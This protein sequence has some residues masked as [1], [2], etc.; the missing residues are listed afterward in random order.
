MGL[1]LFARLFSS[2]RV[3]HCWCQASFFSSLIAIW[4]F[5]DVYDAYDIGIVLS[6][7]SYEP[8]MHYGR[9]WDHL[10]IK[11]ESIPGQPGGYINNSII[12]KST[13]VFKKR[14][15]IDRWDFG[16]E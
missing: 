10:E 11:L 9:S 16:Q 12:D 6:L 15:T 8:E 14:Y 7:P 3:I 5:W 13:M 1:L 2:F 4:A